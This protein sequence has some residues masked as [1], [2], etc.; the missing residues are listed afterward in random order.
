MLVLRRWSPFDGSTAL[1]R[2]FDRL[3]NRFDRAFVDRDW[4]PWPVTTEGFAPALEAYVEGDQFH[5]RVELPGVD[6]K[7]I[8]LSLDDNRLTIKGERKT[9][10]EKKEHGY[11]LREIAHGH[12]ARTV[13][14]P[15]GA[16]AE[17]I[18]ARYDKGVLHIT[19]P[20]KEALAAKKVPIEVTAGD[21]K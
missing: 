5:V 14:L 7:K 19:V 2:E 13:M 10:G 18:N 20:V 16:D 9:S 8:D 1:Q 6:P 15:E 11:V 17:K 4:W 21:Q 3:F 12:F